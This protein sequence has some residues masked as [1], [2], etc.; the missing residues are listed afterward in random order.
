MK[1]VMIISILLLCII[2]TIL[3]VNHMLHKC[4]NL[5]GFFDTGDRTSTRYGPYE[6]ITFSS[7]MGA[8]N[9]YDGN[10]PIGDDS[11]VFNG[12]KTNSK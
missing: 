4:D 1:D 12:P 3:L 7:G 11:F 6:G 8:R 2:N 9:V 10:R 5:E